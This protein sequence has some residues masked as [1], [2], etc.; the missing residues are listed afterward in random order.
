MDT[1]AMIDGMNNKNASSPDAAAAGAVHSSTDA[2]SSPSFSAVTSKEST[3]NA[4]E[5][6]NL[7]KSLQDVQ[8]VSEAREK[9]I[10]E[11]RYFM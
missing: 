11:V 6:N 3:V 5:V 8:A 9:Q 1:I 4:E 7:K 10:A 2:L